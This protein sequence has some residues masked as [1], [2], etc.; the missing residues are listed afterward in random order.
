MA[1]NREIALEQALVAVVAEAARL[2]ISITL[3]DKAKAGLLGHASYRRVE[4]LHVVAAIQE[5]DQVAI[6]WQEVGNG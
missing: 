3:L 1:T 4:E 2:G 5:L 6:G